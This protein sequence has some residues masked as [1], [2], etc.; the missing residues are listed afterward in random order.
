MD[1]QSVLLRLST[2]VL[3]QTICLD[4]RRSHCLC[5]AKWRWQPCWTDVLD[6][7]PGQ[8]SRDLQQI[9]ISRQEEIR[10]WNRPKVRSKS[11]NPDS[12][13]M[14]QFNHA[15][16]NCDSFVTLAQL[17]SPPAIVYDQDMSGQEPVNC[18]GAD[19]MSPLA[20]TFPCG[21]LDMNFDA[22]CSPGQWV[23]AH[24]M[25]MRGGRTPESEYT[26]SSPSNS[27]SPPVSVAQGQHQKRRAQ[28]RA[29]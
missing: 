3:V 12:F 2:I 22:M 9:Y 1:V 13:R 25:M 19:P 24:T 27:P 11:S 17:C 7:M 28:N 26:S 18:T 23:A 6:D 20:S 10:R 8:L 5:S 21:N 14:P 4:L 15:H 16:N 29:A